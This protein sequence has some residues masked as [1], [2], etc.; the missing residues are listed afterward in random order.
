MGSLDN[1]SA[2]DFATEMLQQREAMGK[3]CTS[4]EERMQIIESAAL[5]YLNCPKEQKFIYLSH[6]EEM[7]QRNGMIIRLGF[8]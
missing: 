3:R 8:N 7:I 1:W 4:L 5:L 6:Y 2:D